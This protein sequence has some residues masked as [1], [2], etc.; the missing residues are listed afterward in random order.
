MSDIDYAILKKGGFMRQKQRN[1]FSLRLR[2]IGGQ[3]TAERVAKISEIAGKY[4]HGYVHLTARQGV[5]IPFIDFADIEAVK[6]ELASAGLAPGACGSRVRTVTA[7]QGADICPSGLIAATALAE[8]IDARYF[9][10][11]MPHKF[12]I[13]I[14]G[15]KN[16]CLKAEE[17]DVGVK[18]GILPSYIPDKCTKCGLCLAVCPASAIVSGDEL[19]TLSL[20]KD[21][22]VYC[23]RCVKS[24][25]ADAWTGES[26]Y[27]LSFGGTFG[28][29]LKFGTN[30]LHILTDKN[31]VFAAIDAAIAYFD[32]YGKAG[33]RFAKTIERTGT[34]ALRIRL[35]EG[36]MK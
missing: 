20:D 10:R 27:I 2:V 22:C 21:K 11:E 1:K 12:K 13:G 19:D 6:E 34:E 8:E 28:N 7:C 29:D 30:L 33:E 26:G 18:G 3:L 14:T 4:G 5:E 24:C 9:G 16:N 35:I 17:N 25:P 23:G 31:S 36:V 15:C 32:E